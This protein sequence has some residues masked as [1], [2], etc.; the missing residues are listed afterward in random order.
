MYANEK[1]IFRINSTHI[2]N[3][4]ESDIKDVKIVKKRRGILINS[5]TMKYGACQVM[6]DLIMHC[7]W[8]RAGH[9]VYIIKIN[10]VQNDFHQVFGSFDKFILSK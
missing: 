2:C 7:M 3:Y 5:D 9:S 6:M 4:H 8:H 1:K 10:K